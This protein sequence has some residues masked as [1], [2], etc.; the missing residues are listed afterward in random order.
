M[1][2]G[3][4]FQ[5]GVEARRPDAA[6]LFVLAGE[7][8]PG[9]GLEGFARLAKFGEGDEDRAGCVDAGLTV[10]RALWGGGRAVRGR[11]GLVDE[12]GV[13]NLGL[14]WLGPDGSLDGGARSCVGL[15]VQADN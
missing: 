13:N 12:F 9:E 10:R 6:R 5:F 7:L 4:G 8:G 14:V 1:E 15:S 2:V 11:R 3:Q